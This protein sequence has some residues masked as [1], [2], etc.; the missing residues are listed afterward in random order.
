LVPGLVL[1]KEDFLVAN[2]CIGIDIGSSSLKI[3]EYSKNKI[4][5]FSESMPDNMVSE[6]QVLSLEA[7]SQFIKETLK[8]NHISEKKCSVILPDTLVFTRRINMPFMNS[9]QLRVNIPYE[10]HDFINDDKDKYVYDYAMLDL[11]ESNEGHKE[12]DL[13]AAAALKSTIDNYRGMFKRAGLKMSIAIPSVMAYTNLIY[14]LEGKK[15]NF[16]QS[17]TG[18]KKDEYCFIDLGHTK[19]RIHI[20]DGHKLSASRTLDY[21][22]NMI[23]LAIAEEKNVDVHIAKRYKEAQSGGILESEGCMNIYNSI[24]VEVMRAINFYRFNN[25]ESNLSSAFI[26]GGG[27]MIEP[28]IKALAESTA[29]E[30]KSANDILS[31]AGNFDTNGEIFVCA[32]G[33]AIQ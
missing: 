15:K 10:F 26:C 6:G 30:L 22:L 13:L 24:A 1:L 21:G 5:L 8:K 9:E 25:Q 14:L 23:D 32:V 31:Y 3:A 33:A 17:E 7:M 11:N 2:G 12:I 18:E 19:C 20:F 27:G 29:L 28:L 4:H 16:E